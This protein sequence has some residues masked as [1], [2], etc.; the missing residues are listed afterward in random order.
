KAYNYWALLALDIVGALGVI[1]WLSS[2]A[3]IA[4]TRS[5][6]K[7]PT[8]INACY[9]DGSGGVCVRDE[10]MQKRDVYVAT[11]GYLAGAAVLSALEIYA[12]LLPHLNQNNF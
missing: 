12:P 8:T 7:Y 5:M 2:M 6:F 11:R 10:G 9:N 3:A 1:F 4:S